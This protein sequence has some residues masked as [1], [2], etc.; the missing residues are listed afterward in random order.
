MRSIGWLLLLTSLLAVAC[1]R[2]STVIAGGELPQDQWSKGVWL[3]GQHCAGCHGE[4]GEGSEDGP[5]LVGAEA[6]PEESSGD[7]DRK[8]PLRSYADVFAYSSTEM[9]PL[10]P[11]TISAESM[12]SIL[13]YLAKERGA[14]WEGDLGASNAGSIPLRE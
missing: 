14:T 4:N 10:E 5:A 9:P 7:S 8:V 3:Y 13:A 6:I 2:R 12:W 1:A 11:G